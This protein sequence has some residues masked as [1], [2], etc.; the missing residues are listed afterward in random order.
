[1][2]KIKVL[3]MKEK[4][5]FEWWLENKVKVVKYGKICKFMIH[6]LI[7]FLATLFRDLLRNVQESLYDNDKSSGA[8]AWQISVQA[9]FILTTVFTVVQLFKTASNSS[10]IHQVKAVNYHLLQHEGL[11]VGVSVLLNSHS[12]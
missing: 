8:N 5:M 12:Q 1:M 4:V 11:L 2:T 7:F 9:V 6:S 3:R 10:T